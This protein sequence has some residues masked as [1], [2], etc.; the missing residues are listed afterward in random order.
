MKLCLIKLY[1]SKSVLAKKG[2]ARYT[3]FDSTMQNTKPEQDFYYTFHVLVESWSCTGPSVLSLIL[4]I[5]VSMFC[6]TRVI[7]LHCACVFSFCSS[8]PVD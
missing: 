1:A 2:N 7:K 4:R 3:V 5:L 8:Q 6:L